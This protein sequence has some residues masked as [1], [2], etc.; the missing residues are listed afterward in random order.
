MKRP[1]AFGAEA[2]RRMKR[3]MLFV[4]DSGPPAVGVRVVYG[5]AVWGTFCLEEADRWWEDFVRDLD[6]VVGDVAI[7]G[8]EVTTGEDVPALLKLSLRLDGADKPFVW[9]LAEGKSDAGSRRGV[10]SCFLPPRLEV[11]ADASLV[12]LFQPEL[13]DEGDVGG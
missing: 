10:L 7:S 13:E 12:N 1:F 2:T 8:V 11:E 9:P 4:V 3:V 5:D 6:G